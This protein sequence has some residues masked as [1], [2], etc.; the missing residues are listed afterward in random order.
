M[1]QI[2][3]HFLIPQLIGVLTIFIFVFVKALKIRREK[4]KFKLFAVRDKLLFLVAT[5]KLSQDDRIFKVFYKAINSSINEIK[6][7]N[8]FSFIRASLTAKSAVELEA[9]KKLLQEINEREREVKEVIGEFFHTYMEIMVSNSIV[10]AVILW[11]IKNGLLITNSLIK[12][13]PK[14]EKDRYETYKWF[15]NKEHGLHITP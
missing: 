14:R 2:N 12:L 13:M 7:I 5:G 15:E 11:L 10:L 8:P 9:N 3:F 4:Q 1:E 6:G